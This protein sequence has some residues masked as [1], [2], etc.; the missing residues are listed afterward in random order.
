MGDKKIMLLCKKSVA[1][2]TASA[3]WLILIKLV[4]NQIPISSLSDAIMISDQLLHS[5]DPKSNA[6][7]PPDDP[8]QQKI[9]CNA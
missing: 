3:Y 4:K 1:L 5:I 7:K 2:N 6:S 8:P 9:S